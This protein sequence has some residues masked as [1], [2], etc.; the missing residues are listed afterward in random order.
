M[1]PRDFRCI[2]GIFYGSHKNSTRRG[3]TRCELVDLLFSNILYFYFWYFKYILN[4]GL[5]LVTEYI[6]IAVLILLLKYSTFSTT[7][8]YIKNE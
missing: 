6:Y 7:A 2:P 5:L 4:S 3:A 8:K 1:H